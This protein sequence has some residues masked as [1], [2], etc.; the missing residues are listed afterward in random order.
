MREISPQNVKLEK[1]KLKLDGFETLK[2]VV[3]RGNSSLGKFN[4]AN[5]IT[6]SPLFPK[7]LLVSSN[8]LF[9]VSSIYFLVSPTVIS[10]HNFHI[11]SGAPLI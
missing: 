10:E 3:W 4:L 7:Y 2:I 1:L 11:F 5:P 9:Q 8:F 6:L